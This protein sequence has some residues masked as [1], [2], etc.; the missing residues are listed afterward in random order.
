MRDDSNLAALAVILTVE[1][2]HSFRAVVPR[3][4]R[5]PG[6]PSLTLARGRYRSSGRSDSNDEA[7]HQTLMPNFIVRASNPPSAATPPAVDLGW[8]EGR[9]CWVRRQRFRRAAASHLT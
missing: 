9:V 1:S 8:L 4:H 6:G 7:L 2:R 5:I 3:T